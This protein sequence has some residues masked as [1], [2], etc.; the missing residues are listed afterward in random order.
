MVIGGLIVKIVTLGLVILMMI[1]LPY[2]LM[3][4][5]GDWHSSKNSRGR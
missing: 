3:I 2:P 5:F 4:A 1:M